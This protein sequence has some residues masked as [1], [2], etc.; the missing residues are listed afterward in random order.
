MALTHLLAIHA[1]PAPH[2]ALSKLNP[3]T[4]QTDARCPVPRDG[5]VI[6]TFPHVA[7]APMRTLASVC[8]IPGVHIH[9]QL[10]E[11]K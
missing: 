1:S 5:H 2:P 11:A 9:V 8:V 10:W 3:S 7:R 6:V 4:T